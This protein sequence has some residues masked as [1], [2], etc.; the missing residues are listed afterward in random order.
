MTGGDAVEGAF[1]GADATEDGIDGPDTAPIPLPPASP[2]T[3]FSWAAIPPTSP[4]D[5]APPLGEE[6]Y[7][8]VRQPPAAT[9]G[10]TPAQRPE[11]GYGHTP[12]RREDRFARQA[13]PFTPTPP[14]G[15]RRTRL[16]LAITAAAV[17]AGAIVTV[18]VS[19]SDGGGEDGQNGTGSVSNGPHPRDDAAETKLRTLLPTGYGPSACTAVDPEGNATATIRCTANTDPG[20]PQSATFSLFGDAAA[21]R[22]AFTKATADNSVVVCPGNIQSPGPWRR[23]S[24]PQQS[25]GDLLCA[26]D[27]SRT[28]IM[29]WTS[30]RDLL[31]A[32]ITG[33]L[34]TTSLSGLYSWWTT[35]S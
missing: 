10:A 8:Q 7:S 11:P 27:T 17:I 6:Q 30:T 29:A 23:N 4:S 5:G 20:G 3:P 21:L 13:S 19:T 24:A 9:I 26:L 14:A 34:P 25:A 16:A 15:R 12:V 32:E 22:A 33:D 28:P 1:G 2:F 18:A 35:H 31:L